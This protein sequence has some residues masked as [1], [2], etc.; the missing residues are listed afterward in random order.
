MASQ[1]IARRRV[2]FTM[3]GMKLIF[4]HGPPASGK[5]TVARALATLSGLPV[6]HNH[7][8]VDA[9]AS[10]FAF[11]SDAFIRLRETYW[12]AMFEEAAANQRS[13]IFTFTPEPSVPSDFPARVRTL[14]ERY[15]GTVDFIRLTVEREEQE[16]RLDAPSR[17]E[18]GK[19]RS[20]D[21]LR[22]LRTTFATCEAAMPEGR[23]SIDTTRTTPE[24]AACV[25]T[26]ALGLDVRQA[27]RS[28]A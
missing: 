13:I 11:G 21:L 28:L 10:V 26:E 5:L 4:L 14:V 24:A 2:C 1:A 6:F 3:A 20:L 25:I 7:F 19:L 15:G 23:I 27:V 8:A 18:F 16:A 22:Q 9:A 12:L 17:S